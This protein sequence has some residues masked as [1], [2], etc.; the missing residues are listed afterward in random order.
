MEIF[1]ITG[2]GCALCEFKWCICKTSNRE[3]H[4][5]SESNQ[6][7]PSYRSYEVIA[8]ER[9]ILFLNCLEMAVES[10]LLV[11][12]ELHVQLCLPA[13]EYVIQRQISLPKREKEVFEGI[14]S[15]VKYVYPYVI[16]EKTIEGEAREKTIL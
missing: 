12:G 6:S 13:F 3:H 16:P 4:H 7:L 14:L 9:G 2:D 8:I 15:I 5:E 1:V 11:C 10:R